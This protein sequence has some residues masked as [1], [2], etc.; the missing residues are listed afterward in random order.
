[1]YW[2]NICP[3]VFPGRIDGA[4]NPLDFHGGVEGLGE[5]VVETLSD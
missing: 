5:G 3:G 2:T 1:M 4:V